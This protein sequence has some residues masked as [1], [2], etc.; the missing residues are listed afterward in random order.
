MT[1]PEKLTPEAL[2]I[3]A[4]S[5]VH[6]MH[7][8]ADELAALCDDIVPREDLLDDLSPDR[9]VSRTQLLSLYLRERGKRRR[10]VE[11]LAG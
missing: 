1:L 5:R 4:W 7:H 2:D 6:D 3:L 10:L 9:D 11:L 8:A